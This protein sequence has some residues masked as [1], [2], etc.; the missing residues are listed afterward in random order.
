MQ[1]W[2]QARTQQSGGISDAG[3]GKGQCRS[4]MKGL[5]TVW[6]YQGEGGEL[7]LDMAEE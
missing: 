2:D 7:N 5:E 1:K 3:A 6:S 4:R